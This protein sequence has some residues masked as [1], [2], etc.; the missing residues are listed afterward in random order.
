MTAENDNGELKQLLELKRGYQKELA[1]REAELK[2]ECERKVAAAKKELQGKYLEK[3]VDTVFAEPAP[4]PEPTREVAPAEGTRVIAGYEPET[5]PTP[6][7]PSR[8]PECN[9]PIDPMDKFCS[10]CA[11]PLQEEVKEDAPVPSAG[12]KPRTRHR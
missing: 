10:E 6:E 9:A 5:V 8:C 1:E 12:R 4:A 3:V 7:K 2:A 11:A